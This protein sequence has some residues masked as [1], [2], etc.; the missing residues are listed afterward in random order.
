MR[1]APAL[2]L[3]FSALCIAPASRAAYFG[4][5]KVQY[6]DFHWHVL[7]TPHFEVL[8][9]DGEGEVVQDAARMAERAYAQLSTLLKHD[10][11]KRVPLILYASHSDFQQT[12]ITDSMIDVGTGGVTEL[13]RRRVFLPFTGSYGELEHVLTQATLFSTDGV[14]DADRVQVTPTASAKAVGDW[15]GTYA[16]GLTLREAR[17]KLER[18]LILAALRDSRG[19][20]TRAAEILGMQRPNLYRKMREFGIEP[21]SSD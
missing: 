11:K 6:K 4:K 15:L 20:M 17:E 12:N 14:I 8:F 7:E 18:D 21:E 13:V 3:A 5:N 10:I 16:H 19:N 2:V 1:T 9:Y